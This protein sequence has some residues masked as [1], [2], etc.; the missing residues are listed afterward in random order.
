M[1]KVLVLTSATALIAGAA[2]ADTVF[3]SEPNDDAASANDLG[4]IHNGHLVSANWLEPN[5]IFNHDW[6]TFTPPPGAQVPTL[7]RR[8]EI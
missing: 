8:N 3:E 5:G 6:F 4:V 2:F 7:R 1:R